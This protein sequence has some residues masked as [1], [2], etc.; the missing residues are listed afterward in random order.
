M[1]A[2]VGSLSSN[3]QAAEKAINHIKSSEGE[4][5]RSLSEA[6][7]GI[8]G[9]NNQYSAA[10]AEEQTDEARLQKELSDEGNVDA[11]LGILQTKQAQLEKKENQN[12]DNV[13]KMFMM[14]QATK[15]SQNRLHGAL[16][17]LT[18]STHKTVDYTEQ[19]AAK[20]AKGEKDNYDLKAQLSDDAAR[21]QSLKSKLKQQQ[22]NT[23]QLSA[24]VEGIQARLDD[25]KSTEDHEKSSLKHEIA[26][27]KSFNKV[28]GGIKGE[29]A[30]EAARIEQLE[31]EVTSNSSSA[32]AMSN[33]FN[34]LKG[35]LQGIFGGLQRANADHLEETKGLKDLQSKQIQEERTMNDE[36]HKVAQEKNE[37]LSERQG[38]EEKMK[39]EKQAMEKS[40]Q[41]S[42]DVKRV[43]GAVQKQ[44]EHIKLDWANDEG[45]VHKEEVLADNT[46]KSVVE[47][48]Q[49]MKNLEGVA[50]SSSKEIMK[51]KTN[52]GKTD[53]EVEKVAKDMKQNEHLKVDYEKA[54]HT[55]KQAEQEADIKAKSLA[56]EEKQ[57][58][59][60]MMQKLSAAAG[61]TKKASSSQSEINALTAADKTQQSELKTVKNELAR[62]NEGLATVDKKSSEVDEYAQKLKKHEEQLDKQSEKIDENSKS[63]ST[64]LMVLTVFLGVITLAFAGM[65]M[66][67]RGKL[68]KLEAQ[69]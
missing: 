41:A 59:K 5:Q 4:V 25:L 34:G 46:K 44:F 42:E 17:K 19:V 63:L 16:A 53:N 60:V 64:G 50:E 45:K 43:V 20:A 21:T 62:E 13:Q 56:R 49:A 18:Q 31:R 30:N 68:A 1:K 2:A 24:D 29:E 12:K 23:K 65:H 10:E 36:E 32:T 55:L 48:E 35:E 67:W 37:L 15:D 6:K 7:V 38:L 52:Q 54:E 8:N 51:L 39:E 27:S 9:I 57:I 40:N 47:L 11:A 61:A 69:L 66:M 26:A 33:K 22:V 14:Q 3:A 28:V 58:Q